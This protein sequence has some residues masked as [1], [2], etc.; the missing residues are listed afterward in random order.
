MSGKDTGK[1]RLER[2]LK[3][4]YAFW[5]T[6]DSSLTARES[7]RA[8]KHRRD[9]V[10]SHSQL[11]RTLHHMSIRVIQCSTLDLILWILIISTSTTGVFNLMA[12]KPP[13]G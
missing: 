13:W 9:M 2:A 4:V 7:L 1:G 11:L 12:F 8:L 10:K 6:L 5:R 3:N